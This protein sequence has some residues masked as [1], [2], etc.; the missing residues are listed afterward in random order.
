MN[1]SKKYIDLYGNGDVIQSSNVSDVIAKSKFMNDIN[2]MVSV[3]GLTVKEVN[4]E[5]PYFINIDDFYIHNAEVKRKNM[6]IP[7]KVLEATIYIM[8]TEAH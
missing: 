4:T 8:L 5:T 7:D 3:Y 2:K 1:L 6:V